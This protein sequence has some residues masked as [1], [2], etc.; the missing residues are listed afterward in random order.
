MKKRMTL[1]SFLAIVLCF[2]AV[3][4]AHGGGAF[5]G[6]RAERMEVA[7]LLARLDAPDVLIIDVRR[8][9]DWDKSEA[10]IKNA[11]RKAYNDVGNW[12]ME[13]PKDKDIVL[14]CA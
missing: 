11:V 9:K 14:Y 10:M 2:G 6:D 12:A 3:L 1:V 13:L 5:A 8:G 7:D 4:T